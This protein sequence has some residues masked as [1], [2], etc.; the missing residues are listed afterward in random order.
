MGAMGF[1][2][3]KEH[4]V[5]V[6]LIVLM[7]AAVGLSAIW[8]SNQTQVVTEAVV[9]R[10]S[11]SETTSGIKFA[12]AGDFDANDD[13]KAVL[14]KIAEEE[15]D[16]TL[17]LGDLSYGTVSENE[18]CDMVKGALGATYPV[19]VVSGNHDVEAY[20]GPSQGHIN[21][22]AA[23]LPNRMANT[24]GTYGQNYFFDQDKLARFIM[25]S[26]DITIDDRAYSFAKGEPDYIWLSETIDEA[27]V[28]D[29]AWIIVGMHKNC[30]SAGTK[31]CE[32]GTD[33]LDLLAEKKVDL[34][35]QGHEHGYFRS[36]QLTINDQCSSLQPDDYKAACVNEGDENKAY[37]KGDGTIVAIPGTGGHTLRD[38]DEGRA[39]AQYFTYLSGKNADPVH[40]PLIVELGKD[41]LEAYFSGVDDKKRD[42]FRINR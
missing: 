3:N 35:L 8:V 27:K 36:K 18:W 5:P 34:V 20:A 29:T 17:A 37:N 33:L 42:E 32:I 13:T 25:I 14:A 15:T 16:F 24:Q 22:A 39:D 9:V 4:V 31:T 26:P 7:L 12:A 10:T 41:S 28:N 23:C 40:G 11:A 6:I 30:L 19:Q 21:R 38:V 2:Q 1:I